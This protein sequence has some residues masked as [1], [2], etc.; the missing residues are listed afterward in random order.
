MGLRIAR[1]SAELVM[2]DLAGAVELVQAA[3][4]A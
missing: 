3:L 2:R 4:S 1:V